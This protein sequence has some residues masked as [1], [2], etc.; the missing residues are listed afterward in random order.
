MQ[1]CGIYLLV[2][3]KKAVSTPR[4]TTEGFE[5][6]EWGFHIKFRPGSQVLVY[7]NHARVLVLEKE[8]WSPVGCR[9]MISLWGNLLYI[10]DIRGEVCISKMR[11]EFPWVTGCQS[12]VLRSLVPYSA[13]SVL[14]SVSLQGC[15]SCHQPLVNLT[16]L[17]LPFR[18][19][20]CFWW[21]DGQ[22]VNSHFS[23]LTE[24]LRFQ[25]VSGAMEIQLWGEKI[26]W[27]LP[28]I[29]AGI[30]DAVLFSTTLRALSHGPLENVSDHSQVEFC[31]L[32]QQLLFSGRGLLLSILLSTEILRTGGFSLYCQSSGTH[33]SSGWETLQMC[34]ECSCISQRPCW[35][36]VFVAVWS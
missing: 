19:L 24:F 22:A 12:V 1:S 14:H 20:Y 9:Q 35:Q 16:Q 10:L 8:E 4:E 21:S 25:Q 3:E 6:S 11:L 30:K 33:V 18:N 29:Q 28:R 23:S 7:E 13:L 34:S 2:K 5:M 26:G 15:R 31:L 36:E 17:F 32:C 27:S